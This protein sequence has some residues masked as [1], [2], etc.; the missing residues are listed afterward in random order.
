MFYVWSRFANK[1][2]IS[3]LYE[4]SPAINTNKYGT[5]GLQL[6]QPWYNSCDSKEK[7]NNQQTNEDVSIGGHIP[8]EISPS[9][10]YSPNLKV[11]SRWGD[12][13]CW[14]TFSGMT[15]CKVTRSR[16][17]EKNNILLRIISPVFRNKF[18]KMHTTWNLWNIMYNLHVC[19]LIQV[20]RL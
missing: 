10:I 6:L 20:Q 5:N 18:M 8:I 2:M 15:P 4:T 9:Y 14:I 19:K 12:F 3:W 13:L 1:M 16:P 7:R 17:Q 11:G